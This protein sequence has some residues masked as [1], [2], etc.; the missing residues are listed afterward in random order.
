[1]SEVANTLL[2][3]RA[4]VVNEGSLLLLRRSLSDTHN[5]G[6]WEF[7]GGKIDAGE[8]L[9][10]GLVREV[11]EETG[12]RIKPSLSIAHVASELVRTGKYE[13]RLYVALF[14]VAQMLSGNVKLSMEHDLAE[15]QKPGLIDTDTLTLPS[16]HAL[17]A[18][19][20]L[21]IV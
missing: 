5:A 16:R 9:I 11:L 21:G 17:I 14:Y 6:L 2:V 7:P 15:W 8:E 13:G 12:T 10:D 18:L 1:M 19:G 3:A 4:V 20:K